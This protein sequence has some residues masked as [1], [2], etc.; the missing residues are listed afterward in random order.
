MVEWFL[1]LSPILQAL[2][3]TSFTYFVTAL[4]AAMVF[5]FKEINRKVLDGMLGCA[6]G[7]MIAAS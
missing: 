6:A 3:G 2:I 5:F 4:G 1:E 7:V